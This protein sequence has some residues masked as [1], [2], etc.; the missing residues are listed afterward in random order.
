[1]ELVVGQLVREMT[2]ASL[3]ISD[4]SGCP[5]SVS[6]ELPHTLDWPPVFSTDPLLPQ[7]T[8][9]LPT[10]TGF[11]PPISEV[12]SD[13]VKLELEGELILCFCVSF[14]FLYNKNIFK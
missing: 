9:A 12:R 1:M 14:L 5:P 6:T 13:Q 4:T 2:P 10:A 3:P 7:P 8:N 11:P